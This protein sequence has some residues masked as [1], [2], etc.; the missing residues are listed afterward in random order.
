MPGIKNLSDKHFLHAFKV[1]DRI[2]QNNNPFFMIAW[3][4]SILAI[5]ITFIIGINQMSGFDLII[6]VTTFLLYLLAV[7]VCDAYL[8]N[9]PCHPVGRALVHSLQPGTKEM[10]HPILRPF[11]RVL[12]LARPHPPK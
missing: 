10:L 3:I 9:E 4:G 5:I 7:H 2:I 6:L 11:E 12:C 1:I 8:S